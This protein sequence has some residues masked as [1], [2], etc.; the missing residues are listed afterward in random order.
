MDVFTLDIGRERSRK[1]RTG[2]Q[3][4]RGDSLG[5]ACPPLS[6]VAKRLLAL[7]RLL[8]DRM[9]KNPAVTK[10]EYIARVFRTGIHLESG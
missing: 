5:N 2:A 9:D 6:A 7:P 10:T 8:V 4:G 1:R 3:Q